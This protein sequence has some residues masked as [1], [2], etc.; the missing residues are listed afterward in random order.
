[1]IHFVQT[2]LKSKKDKKKKKRTRRAMKVSTACSHQFVDSKRV[3]MTSHEALDELATETYEH[4]ACQEPFKV[5]EASI[6][7][8]D[9][10]QIRLKAT[11]PPRSQFRRRCRVK[12]NANARGELSQRVK[13]K[14]L[15]V[16]LA[17]ETVLFCGWVVVLGHCP[18]VQ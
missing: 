3:N 11:G 2:T 16:L 1:M 10:A 15:S 5:Q 18:Q 6:T 14:S 12:A 7:E 13:S 4:K 9:G 17:K 8:R